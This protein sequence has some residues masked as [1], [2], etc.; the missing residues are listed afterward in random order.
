MMDQSVKEFRTLLKQCVLDANR[1]QHLDILC[2]LLVTDCLAPV[3]LRLMQN[4]ND[5]SGKEIL[6]KIII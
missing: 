1:R 6:R 4:H 2:E 5:E 3:L